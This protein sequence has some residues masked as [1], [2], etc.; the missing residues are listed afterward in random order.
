MCSIPSP[1][2]FFLPPPFPPFLPRRQKPRVSWTWS[3][4]HLF[5]A[6]EKQSPSS[7]PLYLLFLPFFLFFSPRWGRPPEIRRRS[8]PPMHGRKRTGDEAFST[9]PPP[10]SSLFFFSSFSS[11]AAPWPRFTIQHHSKKTLK[12]NTQGG[13]R[14]CLASARSRWL[15]ILLSPFFLP[16]PPRPLKIQ[17]RTHGSVSLSNSPPLF[18]SLEDR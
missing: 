6:I 18:F 3:L 5:F 12:K 10:L 8:K 1:F 16:P 14:Q 15:H 9:T 2:L 4:G 17:T 11:I 13:P 7:P